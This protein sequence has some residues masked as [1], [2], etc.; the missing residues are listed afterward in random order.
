MKTTLDCI[1]CLLRQTLEV[2][3]LSVPDAADHEKIM[4][5][6]LGLLWQ[7]DLTL[8]P[9]VIAQRI[10]RRL[11]VLTGVEDPYHSQKHRFNRMAL[12]IL[13]ALA[14][15]VHTAPQSLYMAV[16]LAIAGNIIDLGANCGLTEAD[17]RMAIENVLAE[18]FFGDLDQFGRAVSKAERILYLADN[19]GE[20]VID[21]LL[22]EQLR[23]K[24][25]TL[26][27][28]G[29]PVINDATLADAHAAGIH[30][31]CEVIDNG[32]DAPGTVL[33]DCR[34]RFR[35]AFN[36]ADLIIAKGQG[37]YETLSDVS[38]NIFFLFKV[39]CPVV[40]SRIGLDIDTHTL[41]RGPL[42]TNAATLPSTR[43]G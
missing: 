21:R 6:I 16:R 7:I 2:A 17:A 42:K 28:R 22:I 37:N 31:L 10:H 3:R 5:D 29:R 25:I 43:H 23:G 39:K 12:G 9:P 33:E 41:V 13:P 40:A 1:P 26:A 19:S 38:A 30:D 35:K 24:H 34:Q 27:V 11:K 14:A 32:S 4:R 18:P 20:I 8:S 15:K 36:A